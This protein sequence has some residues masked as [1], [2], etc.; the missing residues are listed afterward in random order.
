MHAVDVVSK[1]ASADLNRA[2]ADHLRD[3]MSIKRIRTLHDVD[4]GQRAQH[5][6]ERKPEKAA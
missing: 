4:V 6:A 2:K 5:Q 1:L 3:D